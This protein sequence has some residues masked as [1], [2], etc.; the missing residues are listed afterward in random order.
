[1][2]KD[3]ADYLATIQFI[4]IATCIKAFS[5]YTFAYFTIITAIRKFHSVRTTTHTVYSCG[6]NFGRIVHGAPLLGGFFS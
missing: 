1:M 5:G 2:L 4:T 3:R 6:C